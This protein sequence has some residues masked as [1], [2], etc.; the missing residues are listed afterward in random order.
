MSPEE[1]GPPL[2]W[3]LKAFQDGDYATFAAGCVMGIVGLLRV[4]GLTKYVNK[5]WLK[6]IAIGIAMVAGIVLGA[7]AHMP[8][9]KILSVSIGIGW[10]A[11]GAWETTIEPVRQRIRD[12]RA[13][14][15][16]AQVVAQVP[17]TAP[18]PPLEPPEAPTEPPA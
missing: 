7:I 15:V 1:F 17:T 3:M 4:A 12:H 6:W 8:W 9:T 5:G 18:E 11:I 16:V 10:A 2:S 13:A 14:Q